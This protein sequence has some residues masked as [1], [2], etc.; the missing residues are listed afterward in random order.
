[1]F[2]RKFFAVIFVVLFSFVSMSEIVRADVE[3]DNPSNLSQVS[4]LVNII[5]D[6]G[7]GVDNV[8]NASDV[9]QTNSFD[10][11]DNFT[12]ETGVFGKVFDTQ[13]LPSAV[14]L[15]YPSGNVYNKDFVVS[16]V[17]SLPA[18]YFMQ[19]VQQ[20]WIRLPIMYDSSISYVHIQIDCIHS[21]QNI[22]YNDKSVVND[23]VDVNGGITV[24]NQSIVPLTSSS[25]TFIYHDYDLLR[26]N[27]SYENKTFEFMYQRIDAPIYSDL[28]YHISFFV[29]FKGS[30]PLVD[31]RCSLLF[32]DNDLG[33]E[34]NRWSSLLM[35]N[36]SS[37]VEERKDVSV[38]S[39]IGF[40]GVA[41]INDGMGGWN[42][43]LP[44]PYTVV[45]YPKVEFL[46]QLPTTL[47]QNDYLTFLM[48]F[49]NDVRWGVTV[50]DASKSTVLMSNT[51]GGLDR[52]Y[53]FFSKQYTGVTSH[54]VVLITIF[55][56]GNTSFWVQDRNPPF[57]YFS[58]GEEFNYFTYSNSSISYP[59]YENISLSPFYSLQVSDNGRWANTVIPPLYIPVYTYVNYTWY[60]E[61]KESD[62]KADISLRGFGNYLIDSTVE[63][64]KLIW[65]VSKDIAMLTYNALPPSWQNAL[66]RVGDFMSEFAKASIYV[67]NWVG[68]AIKE[69]GSFVFN[70][71][72]ESYD[73]IIEN[74]PMIQSV[75]ELIL[76]LAFIFLVF[77]IFDVVVSLWRKI[78]KFYNILCCAGGRLAIEF[79]STTSPMDSFGGKMFL[80]G[81]S[82]ARKTGT[83]VATGGT[84]AIMESASGLVGRVQKRFRRR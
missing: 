64:V 28:F 13:M 68:D 53:I 56:N 67:G 1:M 27:D 54:D 80:G 9:N 70:I 6:D 16:N 11:W 10:V 26:A 4:I 18:D 49:S 82:L 7:S 84:S 52:G 22:V 14:N 23:Y 62:N 42:L 31:R 83:A 43:E 21:F 50:Y 48:P 5:A 81:V 77:V 40:L 35:I 8:F 69:V 30:V 47:T 73:W 19:G 3:L 38:C 51:S 60:P 17:F 58:G 66:Q 57:T 46:V 72:L 44:A 59:L 24:F 71:A 61:E 33:V 12:D 15:S 20:M 45:E 2:A 39:A 34:N 37:A 63:A 76:R 25:S 78:F 36:E 29:H 55:V 74:L 32:N 65:S 79:M 41:S 75:L